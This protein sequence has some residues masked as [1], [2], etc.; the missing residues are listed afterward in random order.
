MPCSFTLHCTLNIQ[1][2]LQSLELAP[3][4]TPLGRRDMRRIV[5]YTGADVKTDSKIDKKQCVLPSP[6]IIEAAP[7]G[8]LVFFLSPFGAW[9]D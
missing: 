1:Y 2:S 6:F 5:F 8:G 3:V 9:F 4:K 7:L